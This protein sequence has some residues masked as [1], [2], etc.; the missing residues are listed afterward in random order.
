M[1][2]LG[3]FLMGENKTKQKKMIWRLHNSGNTTEATT[4]LQQFIK[5]KAEILRKKRRL[6]VHDS[7]IFTLR[8]IFLFF[9]EEKS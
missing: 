4:L 3:I 8:K 7:I 5:K 6:L 9:W 2:N 1:A